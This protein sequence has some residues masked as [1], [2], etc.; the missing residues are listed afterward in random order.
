[1]ASL[2]RMAIYLGLSWLAIGVIY[3]VIITGGL[4]RQPPE[5]HFEEA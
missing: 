4:C 2:D 1:M 3:L 5:M